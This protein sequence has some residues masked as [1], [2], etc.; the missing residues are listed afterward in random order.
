MNIVTT[1]T[2]QGHLPVPRLPERGPPGLPISALT[3]DDGG[4]VTGVARPATD[5]STVMP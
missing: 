4:V 2:P 5:G 3:C 1:V